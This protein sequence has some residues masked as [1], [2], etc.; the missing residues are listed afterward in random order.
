M[1]RATLESAQV[2]EKEAKLL[3][4][5]LDELASLRTWGYT[6]QPHYSAATR[7]AL[8]AFQLRYQ[9]YM[10]LGKSGWDEKKKRGILADEAWK[11]LMAARH[12]ETGVCYYLTPKQYEE[13]VNGNAR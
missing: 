12:R 10:A 4:L 7:R 1:S 11:A 9:T 5:S 6:D 8:A 2:S 3:G 13:R